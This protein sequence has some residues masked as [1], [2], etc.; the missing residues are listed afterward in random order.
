MAKSPFTGRV[1]RLQQLLKEKGYT[2]F[3]VARSIHL[4]Y[5]TGFTGDSSFLLVTPKKTILISDDRFAVQI[6][7][8]CSGI[9]TYIRGHDKN[10][11]QAIAH[12]VSKHGWNNVAVEA[13]GLTLAEYERLKE[14]APAVNFVPCSGWVESLRVLKDEGEIRTL[15]KAIQVA[16][17]AFALLRLT[18]QPEH[19]EK[20]LTDA[21]ETYVRQLGG[22]ATAFPPI[23][24][25]GNRSALPHCP[26]SSRK[27]HEAEFLLVDWG[28][29]FQ[30]YHS[31]MTRVILAPQVSLRKTVERKLTDIYTVVSEAQQKAAA[32]IRPGVHVREVDRAARAHIEQAGYGPYFNHGLGHGIGLEIHE[33][34]SIRSN[35]EDILQAGMVITLEPGIYLPDFGGV[36]IEDDFLITPNGVERLTKTPQHWDE[37][38]AEK[39]Y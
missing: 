10:T 22:Q 12:V 39:L 34:P 37:L 11:F 19:S 7:E 25:V 14:L 27:V 1:K 9:E 3:L 20:N 31:D 35:S 5:L 24:G 26:P 8:E 2:A 16:E 18:M 4:Y 36:R 21:I 13:S 32:A 6:A 17:S 15:R 33:A 38:I 23:V 29:K 30:F 28:A